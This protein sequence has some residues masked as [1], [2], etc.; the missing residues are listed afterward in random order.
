VLKQPLEVRNALLYVV[1]NG[2]K[3]GAV[4]AGERDYYSSAPYFDGFTKRKAKTPPEGLL[5]RARAW[6]LTTGW[7]REYGLLKESETPRRE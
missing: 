6:L 2:A 7:S 5:A 3:H 4:K 1:R